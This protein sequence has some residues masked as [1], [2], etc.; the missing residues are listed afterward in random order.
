MTWN[1][2]VIVEVGNLTGS[3]PMARSVLFRWRA[4][5]VAEW[6]GIGEQLV[7]ASINELLQ[8]GYFFIQ[9]L[10]VLCHQLGSSICPQLAGR[11]Q[12]LLVCNPYCLQL[13]FDFQ[14]SFRSAVLEQFAVAKYP[15]R[16]YVVWR[17]GARFGFDV[18]DLKQLHPV[19]LLRT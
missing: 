17:L 16:N 8:R 5:S 15:I 6:C 11:W 3:F 13:V 10:V 7:V 9:K 18:A 1:F 4:S 2:G 14:E 19:A 12:L